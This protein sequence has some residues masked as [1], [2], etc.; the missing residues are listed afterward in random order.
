MPK[1]GR[2]SL[3]NH[4]FPA[5]YACYL[6][7]SIRTPHSTATYIGSTPSPPRRIRQHNG[8]IAGGAWKTKR[9]RPWVMQM[10]VHGFPSNLAALQFEW[11]W[12]QPHRSRHLRDEEV[13]A[14]FSGH[15]KFNYL[16]SNVLVA[17]SM[18]SS[19]P[20]NTWPLHV[21]LF[22]AEAA[23]AWKDAE[24]ATSNFPLPPG[25]TCATELEGV[26][27]KSGQTGT[28]R[29]GPIDVTDGRFTL[30]YL[31][32]MSTV[33]AS[34]GDIK[35]SI[36]CTSIHPRPPDPLITTLCPAPSCTAMSHLTC[37]SSDFLQSENSQ[38]EIIPRGGHCRSCRTYILWGDVVRGCY[39]RRGGVVPDPESESDEME[40]DEHDNECLPGMQ[41]DNDQLPP[42]PRRPGTKASEMRRKL[43]AVKTPR[44][45]L[46]DHDKEEQEFFDLSAV[47]SG[48]EDDADEPVSAPVKSFRTK[49][50][51]VLGVKAKG[52]FML[53]VSK[54]R[55]D[56]ST[57]PSSHSD[58]ASILPRGR[59]KPA[60][61][62]V[63][64]QPPWERPN[65]A[66]QLL[67]AAIGVPGSSESRHLT[68]ATSPSHDLHT[69]LCT[70]GSIPKR[71]HKSAHSRRQKPGSV[72][73]LSLAGM[74]TDADAE[75]APSSLQ[76]RKSPMSQ[77][78]PFPYLP[79]LSDSDTAD[80][81]TECEDAPVKPQSQDS[82][83]SSKLA[84]A[85]SMLSISSPSSPRAR[86]E[87]VTSPQR[88]QPE[89]EIIVLSD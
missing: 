29:L 71:G 60:S 86:V 13:Q 56:T 24:L 15:R 51:K 87:S 63:S 30:D 23:K 1:Q 65:G 4:C 42:A 81:R 66:T 6:L 70:H 31:R 12:Q 20:F 17:R 3:R 41:D 84:G 52:K 48:S 69:H 57:V 9:N 82:T 22:T 43:V 7:K 14:V 58:Y 32:K 54:S 77:L 27:G 46:R 72:A 50:A 67:S 40:E 45:A 75:A 79:P 8:E 35:C 18:V 88:D 39:R 16:R 59:G 2:S 33:L 73:D 89:H 19:H 85:V 34:D 21:K 49:G 61:R 44:S 36:C 37:L 28:E 5:F 11:A 26:D 55:Y 10:I 25:F 47:S 38:T 74:A 53:E 83:T 62:S 78:T 76:I 64:T 68:N 80:L